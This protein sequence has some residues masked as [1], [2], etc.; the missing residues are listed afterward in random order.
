MNEL[1]RI[2][3]EGKKTDRDEMVYK[4]SQ[5]TYGFRKFKTIRAFGKDIRTNFINMYM[6]NDEQNHLPNY[7]GE[8]KNNTK[9]SCNSNL[10]KVR[11]IK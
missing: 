9:P 7:I 3:E 8:F 2:G 1:E 5:K 6:A 4:E 10:R 11:R